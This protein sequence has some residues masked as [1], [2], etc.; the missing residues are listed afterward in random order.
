M[1]IARSTFVTMDVMVDWQDVDDAREAELERGKEDFSYLRVPA[2]VD[3]EE[4]LE[5][6]SIEQL[7]GALGREDPGYTYAQLDAIE[8]TF[9]AAVAGDLSTVLSLANRVFDHQAQIAAV[10]KGLGW[11]S[12]RLAA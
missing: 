2:E 4:A 6:A 1:M 11:P 3:I 12:A 8:E 7:R 10:E 9:R 5:E